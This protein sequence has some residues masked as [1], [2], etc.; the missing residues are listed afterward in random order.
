MRRCAPKVHCKMRTE[1]SLRNPLDSHSHGVRPRSGR[2]P[3]IR[4]VR[5]FRALMEIEISSPDC[6]PVYSDSPRLYAIYT[7]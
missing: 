4:I 6:G 2:S 7:K 3:G 1:G 5:D